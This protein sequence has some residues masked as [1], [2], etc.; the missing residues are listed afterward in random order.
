MAIHYKSCL[1]TVRKVQGPF[2]YEVKERVFNRAAPGKC[3]KTCH[4]H[5]QKKRENRLSVWRTNLQTSHLH[6]G[7]MRPYDKG[8]AVTSS[9]EI[10]VQ[11]NQA[12]VT[13][14]RQLAH[15]RTG[16]MRPYDKGFA[17]K[18]AQAK[19]LSNA[20]KQTILSVALRPKEEKISERAENKLE[21]DS[22][23]TTGSKCNGKYI[24]S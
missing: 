18:P 12:S 19:F 14:H 15:T 2:D 16:H 24:S 20:F 3:L 9:A 21:A 23:S 17:L 11:C 22:L 8:F 5:A 1:F 6:T 13:L 10:P 4:R 7:H